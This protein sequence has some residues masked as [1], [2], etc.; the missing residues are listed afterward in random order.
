MIRGEEEGEGETDE[1][2]KKR[3]RKGG[4]EEGK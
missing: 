1:R 3:G 4:M 2:E